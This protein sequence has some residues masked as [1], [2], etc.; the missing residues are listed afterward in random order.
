MRLLQAISGSHAA[1]GKDHSFLVRRVLDIVPNSSHNTAVA[2]M[3]C[4]D[5]VVILSSVVLIETTMQSPDLKGTR[6]MTMTGLFLLISGSMSA[7]R[8]V[9][10]LSHDATYQLSSSSARVRTEP[11]LQP[12][13]TAQA[14]R[15]RRSGKTRVG[16]L[17]CATA[18]SFWDHSEYLAKGERARVMLLSQSK[19]QATVALGYVLGLLESNPVTAALIEGVTAE[20]ISLR[21]GVDIVV[22]AASYRG[23]R[24][25]STPLVLADE[26]SLWRDTESSVNPAKE[27]FRALAPMASVSET[28]VEHLD[29]LVERGRALRDP[30]RAASSCGRPLQP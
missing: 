6:A 25:F 16:A 7:F 18:A 4:L 17:L 12:P 22:T 20:V 26:T 23:V 24:G 9:S 15:G 5:C 21:D 8:G 29:A 28:D 19:D 30:T 1:K 3:F 11:F 10:L 14:T 2:T 13:R 27:I